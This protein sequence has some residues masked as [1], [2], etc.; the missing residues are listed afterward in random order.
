M[1]AGV[2]VGGTFTDFVAF[3]SGQFVTSKVPS[4]PREPDAA[5][6]AGMRALGADSIAHGTTVATNAIVERRGART[7]LITTAGFEDLL[8]IGRQNRPSLYDWRMI[9]TS[10]VVPRGM[11][12]GVPERI[13]PGGRVLKGLSKSELRRVTKTLKG[14]GAEAV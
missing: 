7:A 14:M 6:V 3:R 5:V 12:L 2:D 10:P 9:R 11:A 1:R 4:R 8:I 13:G